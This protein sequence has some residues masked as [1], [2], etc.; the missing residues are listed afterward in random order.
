MNNFQTE[1]KGCLWILA[2]TNMPCGKPTFSK[3][4]RNEDGTRTKQW[5]C[6]C[7]QHEKVW[8][9]D[10][11][12]NSILASDSVTVENKVEEVKE[13]SISDLEKQL[14]ELQAK[15]NEAK[16]IEEER[17]KLEELKKPILIEVLALQ[18][19]FG[20]N[21][22]VKFSKIT[23]SILTVLR[24]TVGRQYNHV[25]ETNNIPITS[26]NIFREEMNN[27]SNSLTHPVIEW[28]FTASRILEKDIDSYINEKDIHVDD[29]G[30]EFVLV[31]ARRRKR[32]IIDTIVD[33]LPGSKL[34][35]PTIDIKNY[36]INVPLSE[37]WRIGSVI[38][39]MQKF[40][41]IETYDISEHSLSIIN[42]QI[43]TRQKIDGAAQLDDVENFPDIN[44]NGQTLKPFQK[45]GVRF[46][47]LALG[48][49][50]ITK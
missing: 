27:L 35:N 10:D 28:K 1:N 14:L 31:I 23:D 49:G 5:K 15:L 9:E 39:E 30:K 24:N 44:L 21:V 17:I 19:D 18:E 11:T 8:N 22:V 36:R 20:A 40:R 48:L 26:W 37:G 7:P 2:E 3:V 45:V 33:K 41:Y 4:I 13:V 16:R 25:A 43:E 12:F 34:V 46:A 32:W 38:E 42:E 6:A 29:N 47:C 50:D